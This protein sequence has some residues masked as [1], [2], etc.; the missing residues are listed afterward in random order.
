MP[1]WCGMSRKLTSKIINA[2]K[3]PR[4]A[5]SS[6][7][8]ASCV[9]TP[10]GGARFTSIRSL[11]RHG[12]QADGGLAGASARQ[13][14]RSRR[15]SHPSPGPPRNRRNQ[16][17]DCSGRR[18]IAP[19]PLTPA[20]GSSI[21]QSAPSLS[22]KRNILR[23][24]Q[25]GPVGE[26]FPA[27]ITRGPG[28]PARPGAHLIEQ[29]SMGFPHTLVAALILPCAGAIC[30]SGQ[31]PKPPWAARHRSH[32]ILRGARPTPNQPA[33]PSTTIKVD[34]KLVNVFVTVTDEHG[35][36]VATSNKENFP[37]AGRR[38]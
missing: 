23:T 24:A 21:P 32:E 19:P 2:I 10:A 38:Q 26:P 22:G 12:P 3:L 20:G 9:T 18:P 31:V 8:R 30:D 15:R 1:Q 35:A 4:T 7:S 25:S 29:S 5:R 13:V 33:T 34:V 6:S 17:V 11:R 27:D 36:P 16:R 14:Q 28:S 37:R